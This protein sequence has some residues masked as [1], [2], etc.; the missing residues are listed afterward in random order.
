MARLEVHFELMGKN[1][2]DRVFDHVEHIPDDM[3]D[4]WEGMAEDFWEAERVRF[5]QEGPGWRP[6]ALST[7]RDRVRHGYPAEHPILVRTGALKASLT[8]GTAPG[9]IYEV[10]PLELKL[11][12]DLKTKNGYT[13]ATIHQTGSIRVKDRPPR[14]TVV[15]IGM[16]LR[17]AWN[18]RLADWMRE[19]LAYSGE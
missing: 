5:E 7:Q 18:K 1:V 12:S 8:D 16:E 3:R 19:E 4:V 11:G 6:L 13:L 17:S 9:A 15:H 14:R 2:F 10:Y